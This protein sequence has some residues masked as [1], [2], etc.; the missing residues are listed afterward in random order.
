[1]AIKYVWTHL[2]DVLRTAILTAVS[3]T[4]VVTAHSCLY[5]IASFS[6][7][8]S[9]YLLFLYMCITLRLCVCFYLFPLVLSLHWHTAFHLKSIES[10]TVLF[11]LLNLSPFMPV[12]HFTPLFKPVFL[13]GGHS[14]VYQCI[15]FLPSQIKL[16]ERLTDVC[17]LS[18]SSALSLFHLCLTPLQNPLVLHLF[19]CLTQ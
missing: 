9:F 8:I 15:P 12:F 7:S 2:A 4:A 5:L 17:F 19:L 10:V 6:L 18:L 11:F 14:I 3:I 13:R 1:M 16:A